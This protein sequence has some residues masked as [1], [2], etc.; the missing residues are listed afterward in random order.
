MPEQF[1]HGYA[2][3]VGVNESSVG[4]WSLP[5]IDKDVEALHEVLTH[6][7]RC[8]YP[9]DHVKVIRGTEATR[10]GILGGLSWLQQRIQAATGDDAT[11]VVYY[12]GHGWRDETVDPPVSYLVPYD[13]LEGQVALSALR[14]ADLSAAI[15]ALRPQRLLVALDCCHAGG[16]GVKGIGSHP[17]GYT[18]AAIPPAL[19]MGSAPSRGKGL[20]ALGIGR[21]RAVL[22]S[23]TGEQQSYVRADGAMSIFTY[24]LIE[25]LTGH[26]EPREGATE[27]LVSD[28]MSHVWRHVPESARAIGAEQ[29]PDYQV[30]GNF[31]ISLL[32][33]G[34]GLSKGQ[35]APDPL[36]AV[37]GSRGTRTIDTG[38]GTYIEGDVHIH[39]GDFIGG[40]STRALT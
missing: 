29:T 28:V 19:L 37:K 35:L 8:A 34:K 13:V 2:L 22:S 23:S 9:E 7:E 25:A 21:G 6:P 12:S 18:E 11:V 39:D 36:N 38:G 10:V 24:H 16:M 3:I 32:M 17:A 27:V 1:E 31:A 40:R 5:D 30:S 20:E 14:A 26:A 33:G 4:S 15:A